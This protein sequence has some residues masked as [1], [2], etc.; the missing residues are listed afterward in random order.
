VILSKIPIL[1]IFGRL[2]TGFFILYASLVAIN[3]Y[4]I[5]VTILI[6]LGLL[7]DI[8]D[9]IIARK[10]NVSTEK[11]RRLD[12]T[13]DQVFYL[14]IVLASYIHCPAF[15]KDRKIEIAIILAVEALAYLVCFLKFKK[16]IA[17]HSIGA[18]IWSLFLFALL[19]QITF[20][21]SS[22]I[23]FQLVFWIGIITRLEIIAITLV[24][25]KWTN[26]IP[27][28]Y[29]AFLLRKGKTIKRNKLFN[30]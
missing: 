8:F 26:D 29:H 25:K 22:N 9:G 2:I 15:F 11:L 5:I 6:S 3:N 18:K 14:C 16:E 27:S 24:L 13:I 4:A 1:L 30:G 20:T 17:F 7:S 28:V 10:L 21:C 12:S 23:I 19:I